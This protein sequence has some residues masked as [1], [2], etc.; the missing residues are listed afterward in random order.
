M[1]ETNGMLVFPKHYEQKMSIR[2]TE[3]AIKMI[4]DHFEKGLAD[5]LNLTRVSAPLFVRPETGLNDNLNGIERPVTFDI[6]ESGVEV[7]IVQSLAK[8]KRFALK[9]YGFKMGEG[10]YTDMNAI[11]RDKKREISTL[12][13]LISGIGN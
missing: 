5:T 3:I 7:E 13:M 12:F 6:K 1:A 10:I 11:R 4:K 8:W 2:E 9:E